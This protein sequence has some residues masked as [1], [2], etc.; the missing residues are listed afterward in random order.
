MLA[1]VGKANK[2]TTL[3]LAYQQLNNTKGF[4]QRQGG[5]RW[6]WFV[7]TH[8]KLGLVFFKTGTGFLFYFK[9]PDPEPDF[10]F[11]LCVKLE[12]KLR[13]WGGEKGKNK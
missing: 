5:V 6:F 10:W 9:E 12:P 2:I 13:F 11:H 3:V 8:S 1:M 7:T 4:L